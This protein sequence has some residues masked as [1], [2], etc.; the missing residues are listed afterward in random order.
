MDLSDV[1]VRYIADLLAERTGQQLT[2][3][4][5]WRIGTALSGIF[6]ERGINNIEQ[7]CL[8]YTSPS[9]RDA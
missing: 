7:L 9:P 8:L 2:E 5:L 4:R 6:R 1:S 3:G